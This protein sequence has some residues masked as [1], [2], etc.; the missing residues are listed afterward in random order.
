MIISRQYV[1][2]E[3]ILNKLCSNFHELL[4]DWLTLLLQVL[5]LTKTIKELIV[6]SVINQKYIKSLKSIDLE[7]SF[8]VNCRSH[9]VWLSFNSY[10]A[11]SKKSKSTTA[12]ANWRDKVKREIKE[13]EKEKKERE[14]IVLTIKNKKRQS[15][16]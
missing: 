5:S 8:F 9:F 1:T 3:Y 11:L 13:K 14:R 10:P 2:D 4:V 15:F 16:L 6:L 12:F 7:I